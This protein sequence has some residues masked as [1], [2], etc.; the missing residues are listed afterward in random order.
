MEYALK[1]GADGIFVTGCRTGDCYFRHGNR[2]FDQRME[3][4]RQP[5]LRK[6]ADRNRIKV[7][8]AA[9]TDSKQLHN[10]INKF[11]D[12]LVQLKSKDDKEV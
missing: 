2:W 6:R 9:E 1:K 3:G 11:Q 4:E 12:L 7:F 5:I 10:E 8:R